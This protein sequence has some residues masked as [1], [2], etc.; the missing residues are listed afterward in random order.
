V[1]TYATSIKH[2]LSSAQTCLES[3]MLYYASKKAQV[4]NTSNTLHPP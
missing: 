3:L 1:V 2:G 4:R